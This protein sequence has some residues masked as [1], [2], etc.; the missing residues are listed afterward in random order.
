MKIE[1]TL[2]DREAILLEELLVSIDFEDFGFRVEDIDS[3][4]NACGKVV[5]AI[6]SSTE[7]RRT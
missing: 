2:T 1:V 7:M 3:V 5:D 6:Q 4:A